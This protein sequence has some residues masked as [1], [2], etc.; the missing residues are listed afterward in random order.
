MPG[1]V[2]V[3]DRFVAEGTAGMDGGRHYCRLGGHRR[4]GGIVREPRPF[5]EILERRRLES[6]ALPEP[7]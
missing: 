4:D 5:E 7:K 6:A 2:R 3:R 1:K